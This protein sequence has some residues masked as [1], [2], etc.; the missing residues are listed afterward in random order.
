D[1][2]GCAAVHERPPPRVALEDREPRLRAARGGRGQ[3]G[4]AG[5]GGE[6]RL[7]E[8]GADAA[9][10]GDVDAVLGAE[11]LVHDRA[12]DAGRATQIVDRETPVALLHEQLLGQFEQL[13]A[14][15]LAR[16]TAVLVAVDI[17]GLRRP[18]L[19]HRPTSYTV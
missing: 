15:H 18:V 14:A 8:L 7:F 13:A 5:G 3:I 10:A 12:A 17:A 16:H 2:A 1:E 6:Q 19:R 9:Q 4:A 11:V